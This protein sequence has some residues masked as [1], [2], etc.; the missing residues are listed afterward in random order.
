MIP[1]AMVTPPTPMD[2][3]GIGRLSPTTIPGRTITFTAIQAPLAGST[4]EASEVAI[5]A[6]LA[7]EA[8][9]EASAV[10]T[11]VAVTAV[12]DTA[13][14]GIA[15]HFSRTSVDSEGVLATHHESDDAQ[16]SKFFLVGPGDQLF[17]ADFFF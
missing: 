16:V 1:R 9:W 13:A 17:T 7:A 15:E 3:E 2:G 11:A 5:R 12:A 14:A 8:T 6:A 4:R 10:A